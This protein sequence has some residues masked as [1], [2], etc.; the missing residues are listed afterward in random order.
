MRVQ[1]GQSSPPTAAKMGRKPFKPQFL[2][3]AE[4]AA[5]AAEC[6]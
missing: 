1:S 6:D 3:A 4:V 5:L 2:S